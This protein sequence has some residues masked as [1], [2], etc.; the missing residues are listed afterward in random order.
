MLYAIEE[1]VSILFIKVPVFVGIQEVV[2]CMILDRHYSLSSSQIACREHNFNRAVKLVSLHTV[3]RE[4]TA[5]I[6]LY[7]AVQLFTI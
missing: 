4:F 1:S 3:R 2:S 7:G 6:F 5:A